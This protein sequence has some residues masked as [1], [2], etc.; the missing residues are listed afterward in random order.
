MDDCK[1]YTGITREKLEGLKQ[2]LNLKTTDETAS[3]D[4]EP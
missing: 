4:D 2:A 1:E 3:S